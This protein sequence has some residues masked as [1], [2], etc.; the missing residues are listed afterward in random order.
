MTDTSGPTTALR[1]AMHLHTTYSD[2]EFTMSELRDVCVAER[3][4]V[5]LTADHADAVDQAAIERYRAEA[6]SLSTPAI[7]VIPGL[8][9][10]CER[11]MHIVGYGCTTLTSSTDPQ[12]VIRHIR[13]SGGVSVIAHPPTDHFPWIESFDE[14]PDGVEAWNSKYDGR[15]APRPE[16][17]ALIRRLQERR[18]L[19]RAFYGIDLHWRRQSRKLLAD[20]AA[21]SRTREDVLEAL[22][23][24]RFVGRTPD[25]V[26]PS[27]GQLAPEMAERFGSLQAKSRRFRRMIGFLKRASGPLGRRIPAGLKSYLRRFS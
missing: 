2:G 16:T 4:S 27:S 10:G 13:D 11:R 20:I 18:P 9:F 19:L 24:G 3:C 23:E 6:Q 17:F 1:A 22:R 25:W 21:T 8:E 14:L 12:E 7:L 26:L 15:L 5:M